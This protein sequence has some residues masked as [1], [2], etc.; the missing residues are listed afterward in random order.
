[1]W[2]FYQNNQE[3]KYF[4]TTINKIKTINSLKIVH[5]IWVVVKPHLMEWLYP[6]TLKWSFYNMFILCV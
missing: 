3:G 6:T 1:M 2:S 5:L 4:G